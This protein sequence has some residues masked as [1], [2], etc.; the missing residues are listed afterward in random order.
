MTISGGSFMLR[1]AETGAA[2]GG[3]P[4]TGVSEIQHLRISGS[5]WLDISSRLSASVGIEVADTVLV[6]ASISAL[7][8]PPTLFKTAPVV[9]G[10]A[11]IYIAYCKS[12]T[13]PVEPIA[14]VPALEVGRLMLPAG[15]WNVEFSSPTTSWSRSATI[16]TAVVQ[17]IFLTVQPF[18]DYAGT[19]TI[20]DW[21]A[22]LVD[23]DTSDVFPVQETRVFITSLQL[24]TGPPTATASAS[25]TRPATRTDAPIAVVIPIVPF[26]SWEANFD[27]NWSQDIMTSWGGYGTVL[28]V[29]TDVGYAKGGGSLSVD[30]V[31]LQTTLVQLTPLTILVAVKLENA[32][33]VAASCAVAIFCDTE[34]DQSHDPPVYA[35][36]AGQGL[37]WGDDAYV[38]VVIGRDYPLVNNVSSYWFGNV[39][40]IEMN[41]WTQTDVPAFSG[42]DSA[43]TFS[44]Q[45]IDL[46]A[47]GGAARSVILRSGLLAIGHPALTTDGTII[48]DWIDWNQSIAVH[49]TVTDADILASIW[50]VVDADASAI[51]L[52]AENLTTGSTVDLQMDLTKYRFSPG[53]HTMTFHAI[54]GRGL[55]SDPST[56]AVQVNPRPSE[57]PMVTVSRSPSESIT[58]APD[59]TFTPLASAASS[60]TPFPAGQLAV[61]PIVGMSLGGLVLMTG[62]G[63]VAAFCVHRIRKKREKFGTISRP[64]MSPSCITELVSVSSGD[65]P[66]CHPIPG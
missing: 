23:A 21:S 30:G 55:V 6:N 22:A 18:K 36:P 9:S 43:M 35:M 13:Q 44:W 4:N 11:D 8:E 37:F 19:A 61:G 65:S 2:I 41:Y 27:V 49:C 45:G 10:F 48:P 34:V 46:R 3:A 51:E 7:I 39:R 42:E 1:L 15:I 29:G 16:D 24:Q 62:S 40:D 5:V 56:I 31:T 63:V 26:W 53:S 28:K 25:L 32:K 17:R 20:G 38:L 12:E 59:R 14:G 33:E 54:D 47:F 57:S 64:L 60:P 58:D 52:M 66:Y 50:M